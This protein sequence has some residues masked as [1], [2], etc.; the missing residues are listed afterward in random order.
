MSLINQIHASIFQKKLVCVWFCGW[1][2]WFGQ[3]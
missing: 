2:N 1:E 3:N